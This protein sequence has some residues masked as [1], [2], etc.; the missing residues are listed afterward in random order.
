[1]ERK[2][3]SAREEVEEEHVPQVD[4]IRATD[5]GG[6]TTKWAVTCDTCPG[7]PYGN[8][9]IVALPVTSKAKAAAWLRNHN[10]QH[11]TGAI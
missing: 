1:M 7:V 4:L 11:R 9:T 5:N 3:Y 2:E 8:M 10:E 6:R